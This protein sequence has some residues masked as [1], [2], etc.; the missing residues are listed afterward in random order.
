MTNNNTIVFFGDS[1]TEWGNW[2][3]LFPNINII[4]LGIAGNSTG[5]MLNRANDAMLRHAHQIFLLAGI[6]DLGSGVLPHTVSENIRK[7]MAIFKIQAPKATL[8]IV[9]ILPVNTHLWNNP[10]LS[11]NKIVTTNTLLCEL[12][13]DIKVR[14]ANI[15][16]AFA[17]SEGLLDS[18]LSNDGL[19]L[20]S[21]GY[22][23]YKTTIE[24]YF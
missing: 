12:A 7:L 16:Y 11:V 13:E 21:K 15:H 8:H 22:T 10:K 3:T 1:L 20:N 14:F 19:H 4:N 2:E 23:L 5:N 17:N 6:N 24:K 9:S 18:T